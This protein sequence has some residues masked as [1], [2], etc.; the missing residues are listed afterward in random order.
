MSEDENA[1][2][3]FSNGFG[4]VFNN[5]VEF[6]AKKR[7]W[8]GGSNEELPLRHVTSVRVESSRSIVGGILLLIVALGLLAT[9]EAG[10]MLFGLVLGALA[11]LLLIGHPSVRINTAGQ[12]TRNIAGAP[13]SNSEAEKFVA[14]IGEKL[15]DAK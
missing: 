12:D 15:Y 3:Y 10:L 8:S 7:W 9:G 2:P 4:A 14:A 5:R 11:L 6:K 1:N 13:G